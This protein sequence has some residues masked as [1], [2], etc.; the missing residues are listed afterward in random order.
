[1]GSSFLKSKW[2]KRL[3]SPEGNTGPFGN[4]WEDEWLLS[5]YRSPRGDLAL[6]LGSGWGAWN[7]YLET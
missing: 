1:M 7:P 5:K 6:S 4:S 3:R 2:L